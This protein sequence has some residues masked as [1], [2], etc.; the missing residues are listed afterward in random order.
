MSTALQLT[1]KQQQQRAIIITRA[2]KRDI[3]KRGNSLVINPSTT[4]KY[5]SGVFQSGTYLDV[6]P[7]PWPTELTE[8]IFYSEAYSA[9]P[10][11]KFGGGNNIT[12]MGT[13]PT[14]GTAWALRGTNF[15]AYVGAF[16]WLK[17]ATF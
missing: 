15:D 14:A 11:I 6:F 5:H 9:I 8:F 1:P 10:T 4:G 17:I 13:A 12:P 3:A 7:N 2:L 16:E